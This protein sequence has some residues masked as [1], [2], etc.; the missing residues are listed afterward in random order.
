MPLDPEVAALLERQKGQPPRSSLS[1]AETRQR[2]RDAGAL[3][4]PP[5]PLALVEDLHLSGLPPVRHYSP[6]KEAGQPVVIFFH[7]GRFFSGDLE[8]HDTVCRLLAIAAACRVIAVDY[9]LAPEH[10]FP[11]A[12]E[13]AC[14]TLEWVSTQGVPV[15]IAGD[16]AGANLAAVAALTHR[17][18]A[19]RCQVLIYPMLDPECSSPSYAEY[20][21]GYGPGAIDMQ[22]GWSLYLPPATDPRDPLASPLHAPDTSAQPPAFILTAEYDTLRDEGEA[23]ARKL[24][25]SGNSVQL[26]RYPGA[27]HGFFTMPG[28]LSVARDA[29]SN[30][31]AF[32][33]LHL[34]QAR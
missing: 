18:P 17:T 1:V 5:P 27:I 7:G 15:A 24:I 8:S 9:R 16:S 3:A 33:R 28:T 29:L 6:T 11:A 14:R 32:L 22:R 26:R 31:A 13:D 4:G 23:Y 19:L 12:A 30:V 10:P 34:G 21:E 20:A 2:L 25:E